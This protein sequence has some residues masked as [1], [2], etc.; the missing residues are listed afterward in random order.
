[1]VW[2]QR[3][4]SSGPTWCLPRGGVPAPAAEALI[5]E[6][7]VKAAPLPKSEP[8]DFEGEFGSTGPRST[9]GDLPGGDAGERVGERVDLRSEGSETWTLDSGQ[10]VT[11]FFRE[12]KWFKHASGAWEK[13]DPSVVRAEGRPGAVLKASGVGFD[14]AFGVSGEG[15]VL[16]FEGRELRLTVRGAA[17]VVPE[18]DKGDCCTVW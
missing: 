4:P 13:V 6:P 10:F 18:L 2:S 16:G 1:M 8:R 5:D 17:G 3:G 15:V 9:E 7:A 11:E 14:A 12:P